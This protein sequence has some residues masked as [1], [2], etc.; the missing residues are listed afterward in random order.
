MIKCTAAMRMLAYGTPADALDENLKI[1][2]STTLKCLGNFAQGMIE[3]FGPEFLRPPTVEETE[4]ILQFNESRGFPG[5]LGSIDCM[6]WVWK[7]YPVAWRGQYTRGDKGAPTMIL[8]AMATHDLGIWH[9]YFGVA[10]ANND[11][12]VLNHSPLFI[13][14]LKGEAPQVHFSINGTQYNNGYYLADGIYPEWSAFVKAITAPQSEKDK[15]YAQA[16]ESARKDIKRAFGVLQSR[17]NIV[18]RPARK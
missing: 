9:G 10:G 16:Q 12:N 15:L 13:Q 11:I 8:E 18:D 1:G 17:F 14:A 6:H 5:L 4:R 2:K 3:T 7:N